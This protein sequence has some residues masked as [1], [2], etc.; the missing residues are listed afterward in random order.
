MPHRITGAPLER[1]G[2]WIDNTLKITPFSAPFSQLGQLRSAGI[3]DLRYGNLVDE[4][5]KGRDRFEA[6]GDVRQYVPL[7]KDV[8]CYT[9]AATATGKSGKVG[10]GLIGDG[11][12]TL[13]SALGRHSNTDLNLFFP[14]THQWVGRNM[15]HLDLLNHP[16]A[17][18]AIKR[19]LISTESK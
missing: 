7:P 11:L 15:I 2:N 6:E 16:D 10:D 19:W 18:A 12:V 1:I 14:K 17:Y 9:M 5:W 3:T 8:Q 4:D 13:D